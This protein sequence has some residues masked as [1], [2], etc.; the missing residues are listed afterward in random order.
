MLGG[1]AMDEV[2]QNM[3]E[4]KKNR[5]IN[6]AIEEFA[7][8]P[9]SKASTNNIVKNAGISKGLLF[10]YFGSKQELYEYVRGFV[11]RKL[12]TEVSSRIDWEN[13][14]IFERIKQIT[15]VKM[16][17]STQYPQL[18]TFASNMMLNESLSFTTATELYR[19]YGVDIQEYLTR[20]YTHN[21][22]YSR[23]REPEKIDKYVNIIGWTI[24]K[25]AD[26]LFQ[27]YQAETDM[28]VLWQQAES[29][30]EYIDIL[31]RAFYAEP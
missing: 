23:F 2:L 9:F 5:I 4:E 11:I 7:R 13:N 28:D 20:V 31:K 17:L 6:S 10:H 1:Y 12:F 8:Y 22:D 29:I 19:E 16:K 24:E 18:F 14:D 27:R 15:L 25:F 26:T 21:I 3:D 30:N